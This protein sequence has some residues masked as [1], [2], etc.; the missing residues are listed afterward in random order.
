MTV[1]D[2]LFADDLFGG[3][4][5]DERF[6]PI[7]DDDETSE[8][9][10]T[11]VR[12]VTKKIV[13]PK[14]ILE[15]EFEEELDEE[16]DEELEIPVQSTIGQKPKKVKVKSE[17]HQKVAHMPLTARQKAVNV[18][19]RKAGVEEIPTLDSLM[20]CKQGDK[21]KISDIAV[22]I[23]TPDDELGKELF[24][25]MPILNRGKSQCLCGLESCEVD[26]RQHC[27]GGSYVSANSGCTD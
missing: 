12:F 15:E 17:G 16:L 14:T 13:I 1:K 9:I 27:Q 4:S 21:V 11:P 5:D 2:D 18:I 19:L 7:P 24:D 26:W 25:E 22:F 3:E 20:R 6:G 10:Q 23:D 8:E